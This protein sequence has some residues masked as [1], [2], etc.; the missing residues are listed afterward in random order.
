[1]TFEQTRVNPNQSLPDFHLWTDA[2]GVPQL[3][4][5][6]PALF[7]GTTR[8]VAKYPPTVNLFGNA[9]NHGDWRLNAQYV[10]PEILHQEIAAMS[11]DDLAAAN[12]SSAVT[13]IHFDGSGIIWGSPHEEGPIARRVEKWMMKESLQGK[14]YLGGTLRVT[15]DYIRLDGPIERIGDDVILNARRIVIDG[16]E[17]PP[18]NWRE[19]LR[20]IVGSNKSP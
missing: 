16:V 8:S 19:A 10:L 9:S 17:L 5:R 15:A 6:V 18:S 12:N 3:D 7:L 14:S 13:S 2:A 11:A 20:N 1:L 4:Y